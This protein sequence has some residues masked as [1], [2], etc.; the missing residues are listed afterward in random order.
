MLATLVTVKAGDFRNILKTL[1][2][3]PATLNVM[4]TLAKLETEERSRKEFESDNFLCDFITS[5]ILKYFPREKII[6]I[7]GK[8]RVL[9]H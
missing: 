8:V 2:T 3:N 7:H 9:R 5:K 6:F 1:A 4:D